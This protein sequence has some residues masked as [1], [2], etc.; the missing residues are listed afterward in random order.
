MDGGEDGVLA[1]EAAVKA[2]GEQVRRLG[3]RRRPSSRRPR[4]LG[5]RH[6][7]DALPALRHGSRLWGRLS[8]AVVLASLCSLMSCNR[9]TETLVSAIAERLGTTIVFIR[10]YM[11]VNMCISK[12]KHYG[13]WTGWCAWSTG[14]VVGASVV[15]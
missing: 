8:A 1:V 11:S 12:C 10:W 5:L 4:V 7:G 14:L 9:P 3:L 2:M 13:G 6:G 15:K